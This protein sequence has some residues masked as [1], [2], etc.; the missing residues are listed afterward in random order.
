VTRERVRAFRTRLLELRGRAGLS[1]AIHARLPE[2]YA[3]VIPSLAPGAPVP[4]GA[5]WFAVAPEAQ[6]A[7]YESQL[8]ATRGAQVTVLRLYPRDFWDVRDAP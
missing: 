2:V 5:Q 8:R 1:E 6:L 4:D 3:A 7:A